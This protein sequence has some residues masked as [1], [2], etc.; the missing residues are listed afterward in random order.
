MFQG[1]AILL[2]LI[3]LAR[4]TIKRVLSTEDTP[5]SIGDF[6]QALWVKI[7]LFPRLKPPVLGLLF[8]IT[9]S[10]NKKY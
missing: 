10:F 3:Q 7:V 6:T 4:D 9:N 5:G 1:E 2:T 8:F